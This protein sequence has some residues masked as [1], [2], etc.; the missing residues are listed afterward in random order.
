MDKKRKAIHIQIY[1][2]DIIGS[3]P[4]RVS[5]SFAL[6]AYQWW[7]TSTFPLISQCSQSFNGPYLGN[8]N[9]RMSNA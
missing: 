9:Y 2:G 7:T 6:H 1:M 3:V 4:I 8:K 5:L